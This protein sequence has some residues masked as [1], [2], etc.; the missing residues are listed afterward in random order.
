MIV[1]DTQ[2]ITFEALAR[3]CGK[4]MGK[5]P[6]QEVK[7]KLYDKKLFDFGEKK[8]FPM[9]ELHFFC[10]VDKAIKDLELQPQYNMEAGLKDSYIHDFQVKKAAGGLKS[11]FYCDDLILKDTRKEVL[12]Y[13]GYTVTASSTVNA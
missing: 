6:E 11:D 4:V 5:D 1:Q 13:K 10:G 8:A 2:S 12:D 7:I 9:R 3:L